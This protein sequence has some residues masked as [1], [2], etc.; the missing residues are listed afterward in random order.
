MGSR[1][2]CWHQSWSR[3][4][5]QRSTKLTI[6]TSRINMLRYFYEGH[7]LPGHCLQ[8]FQCNSECDWKDCF[9]QHTTQ[10]EGFHAGQVVLGMATAG[11]G[12]AD[13]Q[14][15]HPVGNGFSY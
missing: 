14:M 1:S 3:Q 5:Q 10:E 2:L 15:H 12:E 6:I 11:S 9:S 4:Y 8:H 7:D 13:F